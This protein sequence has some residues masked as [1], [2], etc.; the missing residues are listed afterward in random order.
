MRIVLVSAAAALV[1]GCAFFSDALDRPKPVI[2]TELA[3]LPSC[4]VLGQGPEPKIHYFETAAAVNA[5]ERARNIPPTPVDAIVE[6][7]FALIELGERGVR[8]YGLLISREAELHFGKRL[9][10]ESTFFYGA[11]IGGKRTEE[12]PCVLL[13]LPPRH[14]NLVE[15]YDQE[16]VLRAK[17]DT[18]RGMIAVNP[19]TLT[20]PAPAMDGGS[21]AGG[22]TPEPPAP[23]AQPA[24]PETEPAPPEPPP[25]NEEDKQ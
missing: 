3:R 7:P 9:V 1:S 12:S 5:W 20:A 19:A 22:R 13:A 4:G 15:M 24:T 6:G 25:N 14:Y 21:A 23:E 8:G 11:Q 2:V 16:G 18:E 10:L 17:T